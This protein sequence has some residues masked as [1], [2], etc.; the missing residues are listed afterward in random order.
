MRQHA[1]SRRGNVFPLIFFF[2]IEGLSSCLLIEL[3]SCDSITSSLL[4]HVVTN[5]AELTSIDQD[6]SDRNPVG[7]NYPGI[8]E[9]DLR[10]P[11]MLDCPFHH[12]FD[13]LFITNIRVDVA[14]TITTRAP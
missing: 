1:M 8:P 4:G 5:V 10:L 2:R 12:S 3:S 9:H 13:L 6:R 14:I 11:V 7:T